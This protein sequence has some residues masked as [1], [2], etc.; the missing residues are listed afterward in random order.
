MVANIEVCCCMHGVCCATCTL[1]WL[2]RSLELRDGSYDAFGNGGVSFARCVFI[3]VCV[4][5]CVC[6]CVFVWLVGK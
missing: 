6:V 2:Y 3:S 5:V 1:Q 4:C